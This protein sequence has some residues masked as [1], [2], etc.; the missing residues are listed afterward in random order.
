MISE[1]RNADGAARNSMTEKAL[2]TIFAARSAL[3]KNF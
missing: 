2:T 3:V 1:R